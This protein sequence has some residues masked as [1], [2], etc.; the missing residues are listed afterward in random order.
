MTSI[1]ARWFKGQEIKREFTEAQA[2]EGSRSELAISW[3]EL[4]DTLQPLIIALKDLTN[5]ILKQ[6][7]Q[8][9]KQWFGDTWEKSGGDLLAFAGNIAKK[10]TG[11]GLTFLTAGGKVGGKTAGQWFDETVPDFKPS[12][13][14]EDYNPANPWTYR[15][16][17][18]SRR[19]A[20][21]QKETD[22][23]KDIVEAVRKGGQSADAAKAEWFESEAT[24]DEAKA[25]L[26]SRGVAKGG[27]FGLTYSDE[28][29]GKQIRAFIND[30]NLLGARRINNLIDEGHKA[31]WG[32]TA[33]D[34]ADQ[35]R[36]SAKVRQAQRSALLSGEILKEVANKGVE[37]VSAQEVIAIGQKYGAKWNTEQAQAA[38][39][40]TAGMKDEQKEEFLAYY[41][42]A[43]AMREAIFDRIDATTF[44]LMDLLGQFGN[45]DEN[46]KEMVNLLRRIA[47]DKEKVGGGMILN[48]LLDGMKEITGKGTKEYDG[49]YSKPWNIDPNAPTY[50]RWA[51][52][53]TIDQRK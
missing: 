13:D 47:D 39:L 23:N 35:E 18:E 40:Q 5:V 42:N 53:A 21:L 36:S 22:K 51:G 46:S 48:Y 17:R 38:L 25:E 9:V 52:T 29:I 41:D 45:L 1:T 15:N 3:S 11:A 32:I 49:K 37:N 2:L 28:Q 33:D 12:G 44:K 10:I 8:R 4:K 19:R 27:W 6:I 43:N 30:P 14:A 31:K 16:S 26:K 24:I 20:R 34:L 50:G 7:N